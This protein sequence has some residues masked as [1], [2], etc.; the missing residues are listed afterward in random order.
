MRHDFD[1]LYEGPRFQNRARKRR[2]KLIFL[3]VV[4]I[5]S[6][7]VIIAVINIFAKGSNEEASSTID[8]KA[9]EEQ[10]ASDEKNAPQTEKNNQFTL[11]QPSS[12]NQAA[13]RNELSGNNDDINESPSIEE[14]ASTKTTQEP[15][16][17]TA[18]IG[19]ENDPLVIGTIRKNWE[20]VGTIQEGEHVTNFTMGSQDWKEMTDAVSVATG[21]EEDDMIIWWMGNGG[22]PDKVVSTV[23]TKDQE[24][25]YRVYLEWVNNRDGWKPV[26]LEQLKEND[27]KKEKM[28]VN[29]PFTDIVHEHYFIF[30]LKWTTA[31]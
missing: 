20:P 15:T 23:S 19:A 16:N 4:T 27:H 13:N 9:T 17:S 31:V 11:E 21:L 22:A 25:Y 2:M 14:D 10:I 26:L 8:R 24:S 1:D 30:T 5:I 12:E 6:I 3:S 29:E 28:S 7:I 18:P